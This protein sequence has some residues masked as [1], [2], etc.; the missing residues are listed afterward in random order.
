MT[1][2]MLELEVLVSESRLPLMPPALSEGAATVLGLLHS[3][4]LALET[5]LVAALLVFL[6]ASLM[7]F[8][9]YSPSTTVWESDFRADWT[10]SE[11]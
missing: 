10:A 3:D 4:V 6:S 7:F 2:S 11:K 8:A 5:L 1:V 9:G